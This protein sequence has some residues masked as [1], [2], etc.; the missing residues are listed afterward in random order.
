M[1]KMR[2]RPEESQM[3]FNQRTSMQLRTWFEKAG[4][5][6]A[7]HRV[8]YLVFKAAWKDFV[9][10]GES[11]KEWKKDIEMHVPGAAVEKMQQ[12]IEQTSDG[13]HSL[14]NMVCA[15]MAA[16]AVAKPLKLS[17]PKSCKIVY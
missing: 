17:F 14:K 11:P 2:R 4:L 5:R 16:D 7:H 10:W 8:L 6:M 3:V 1:F 13:L 9:Q 12:L 15:F